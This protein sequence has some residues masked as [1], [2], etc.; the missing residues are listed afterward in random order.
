MS[1]HRRIVRIWKR[2]SRTA[3]MTSTVKVTIAVTRM[4]CEA[5]HSCSVS[6]PC[7]VGSNSA[8]VV[9]SRSPAALSVAESVSL[10]GAG[11]CVMRRPHGPIA[12]LVRAVDS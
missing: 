7:G 4:I 10:G 1:T 5:R 12:Q 9:T 11:A 8:I 3:T 6:M 2:N